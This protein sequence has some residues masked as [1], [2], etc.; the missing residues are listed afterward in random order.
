MRVIR[1]IFIL[2]LARTQAAPVGKVSRPEL[3]WNG[4][5]RMATLAVNASLFLFEE[6]SLGLGLVGRWKFNF[7]HVP[8]GLHGFGGS[9]SRGALCR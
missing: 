6:V 1:V 2:F 9:S 5:V 4:M 7:M 8:S 3:R